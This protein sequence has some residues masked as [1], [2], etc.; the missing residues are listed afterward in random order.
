MERL[1]HIVIAIV[2]LVEN[3]YFGMFERVSGLMIMSKGR[4]RWMGGKL[5]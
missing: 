1:S 2:N 4:D 5:E 3:W